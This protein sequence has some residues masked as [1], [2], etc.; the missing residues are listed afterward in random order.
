MNVCRRVMCMNLAKK[1][2]L[3]IIIRCVCSSCGIFCN[4][5]EKTFASLANVHMNTT[6]GIQEMFAKLYFPPETKHFLLIAT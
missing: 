4:G 2:K 6:Y 5:H 3:I 1:V